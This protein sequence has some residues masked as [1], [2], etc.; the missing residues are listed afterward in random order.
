MNNYQFN[1]ELFPEQLEQNLEEGSPNMTENDQKE[2]GKTLWGIA[3]QLRGAMNADDFRG[4]HV[5]VFVFTLSIRIITE[6]SR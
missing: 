2:L 6:V 1:P 3:D 5:I 4:L